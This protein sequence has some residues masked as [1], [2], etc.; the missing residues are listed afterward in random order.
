MVS[1]L[2]ARLSTYR[3]L[4]R[5]PPGGALRDR[6]NFSE[7]PSTCSS[8]LRSVKRHAQPCAP[9][10]STVGEVATTRKTKE[11]P[12]SIS[13]CLAQSRLRAAEHDGWIGV[14][15]SAAAHPPHVR[16]LGI[17]RQREQLSRGAMVP[18]CTHLDRSAGSLPHTCCG[19]AVVV[20]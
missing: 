3:L 14:L 19:S 1:A 9:R 15:E 7:P 2:A 8:L 20:I 5:R 6:L 17:S 18:R 12:A 4:I 13:S 10:V 16:P 11:E